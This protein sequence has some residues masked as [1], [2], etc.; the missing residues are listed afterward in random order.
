MTNHE[1]DYL[2][3][4]DYESTKVKKIN[5]L[6]TTVIDLQKRLE[7]VSRQAQTAINRLT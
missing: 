3:L 2:H 4:Y 6:I 7:L 1:P 5:D